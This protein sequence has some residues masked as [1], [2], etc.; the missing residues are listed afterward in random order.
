MAFVQLIAD[1]DDLSRSPTALSAKGG[2]CA[3][4]RAVV[5]AELEGIVAKRLAH[6]Y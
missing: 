1:G 3:G 2:R 6:A 5:D 4:Y